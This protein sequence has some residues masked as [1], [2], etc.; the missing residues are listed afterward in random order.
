MAEVN[1]AWR[2]SIGVTELVTVEVIDNLYANLTGSDP[3][4]DCIVLER[5]SRILGYC[6]TSTIDGPD[7]GHVEE[8]SVVLHPEIRDE[9]TYLALLLDGEARLARDRS[10]RTPHPGD[11]LRAWTW[12]Q[13]SVARA[14][15]EAAGYQAAHFFY[16]MERPDLEGIELV[17]LPAGLELRPVEPEHWRAIW[18][19]D[20]EAFADDWDPDD[21]SETGFQRFLGEPDQIPGLWQ[22][23]W[24]GDQV[25]GHVLVTVNEAAHERF[26]RREG[27]L[28]SVAVRRPYR[29]RGLARAL[30][31]RALAALRD[32]GET[33]A[34]LG[35]DV[36][37]PNQALGLYTS[38]GF[39]VRRGGAAYEK[40]I[41]AVDRPV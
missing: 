19:A 17:D 12:D 25:A 18:E 34:T 31:L 2:E 26:G 21:A 5:D 41:R 22:V 3:F 16:E 24:D 7:G 27:V 28:D 9:A 38:C 20:I 30:I 10:A 29:R 32:H 33:H 14:A 11:L 35:V 39:V 15:L 6:R 37:N 36:D 4:R 40:R 13:D 23:A 8:A 1:T